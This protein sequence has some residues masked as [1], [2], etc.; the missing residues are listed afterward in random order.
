MLKLGGYDDVMDAIKDF[1]PDDAKDFFNGDDLQEYFIYNV[2]GNTLII[3][4]YSTMEFELE[5]DYLTITSDNYNPFGLADLKIEA[6]YTLIRTY[7]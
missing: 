4:G 2:D 5:G 7:G 1:A 3:N 6:P